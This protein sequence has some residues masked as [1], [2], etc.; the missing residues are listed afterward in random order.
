[1]K[2]RKQ[3]L[4]ECELSSILLPLHGLTDEIPNKYK[5]TKEEK[6]ETFP[7]LFY[8]R[9]NKMIATLYFK[10]LNKE[11]KYEIHI[12]ERIKRVIFL[13]NVMN[14]KPKS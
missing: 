12:W 10:N 14:R 3:E 7:L 11:S 4:F 9:K 2:S 1:M 5:F 13:E 6:R 8:T